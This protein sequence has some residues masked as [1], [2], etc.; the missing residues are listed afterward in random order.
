MTLP[1]YGARD[2]DRP[3]PNGA[4]HL[5]PPATDWPSPDAAQAMFDA[6][7]G[8]VPSGGTIVVHGGRWPISMLA[9]PSKH[10]DL[11][12]APGTRPVF[13]GAEVIRVEQRRNRLVD[14]VGPALRDAQLS[15]P[16][17]PGQPER[18]PARASVDRWRAGAPGRR[19][20]VPW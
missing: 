14:S 16:D 10:W 6:A 19:H 3:V 15:N 8:A 5:E 18:Q 11:I 13:D 2:I 7:Q 17:R 9:V 12:A 4:I 1:F 20:P